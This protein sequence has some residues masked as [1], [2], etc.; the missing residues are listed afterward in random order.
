M[1]KTLILFLLL[2][3]TSYAQIGSLQF[4]GVNEFLDIA[5]ATGMENDNSQT[6]TAWFNCD[7]D[8]TK[9]I[10][11]H[12]DASADND[13]LVPRPCASRTDGAQGVW[14]NGGSGDVSESG[15]GDRRD[16]WHH[17]AF[18]IT[19]ATDRKLYIDGV[20]VGNAT[21]S[22]AQTGNRDN[23][24]IGRYDGS[25]AG[26]YWDGW[27]KNVRW[28]NKALSVAE[29]KMDMQCANK[30]VDGLVGQWYLNETNYIDTSGSANDGSCTNCPDTST[31]AP[32]QS[33]CG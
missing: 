16:Q 7:E 33:W 10:F 21:S 22:R 18:V 8:G 15:G 27:I 28:Y 32:P 26:Q 25:T 29:L 4:D 19:S 17:Y 9:N 31:D 6:I 24:A 20:E 5:C 13:F 2:T 30:P 11:S 14:W 1:I 23:C 12:A 3:L